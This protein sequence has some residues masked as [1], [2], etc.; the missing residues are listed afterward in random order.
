MGFLAFQT[1]SFSCSQ[2]NCF[3]ILCPFMI[4]STQCAG[5]HKMKMKQ[6]GVSLLENLY[7]NTYFAAAN[8]TR[9]FVS[10]FSEV[11]SPDALDEIL[12]IKG[13]PGTGKS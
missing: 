4:D 11:F 5:T 8:S 12:I 13:G 7:R 3:H 10:F 1:A 9:G 6:R 2:D